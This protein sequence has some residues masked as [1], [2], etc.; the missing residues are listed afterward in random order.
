MS[1]NSTKTVRYGSPLKLSVYLWKVAIVSSTSQHQILE[2]L[3]TYRV[4]CR[5]DVQEVWGFALPTMS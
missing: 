5:L 4:F 2:V 1:G 3:E